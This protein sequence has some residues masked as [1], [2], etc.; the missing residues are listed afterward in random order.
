VAPQ[1][2]DACVDNDAHVGA[3]RAAPT[4]AHLRSYT[5]VR[6]HIR[7]I[8]Q[9]R[10]LNRCACSLDELRLALPVG[11]LCNVK[12]TARACVPAGDSPQAMVHFQRSALSRA[13]CEPLRGP[14]SQSQFQSRLLL[15]P[16]WSGLVH[17]HPAGP[18]TTE[19]APLR[20]GSGSPWTKPGQL[21]MRR[22][23]VRIRQRTQREVWI[24]RDLIQAFAF[25]GCSGERGYRPRRRSMGP[26]GHLTAPGSVTA[27]RRPSYCPTVSAHRT[28]DGA[29]TYTVPRPRAVFRCS[30]L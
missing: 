21:V 14:G 18:L 15:S 2:R 13:P 3:A 5:Q 6:R 20:D 4:W 9:L 28:G 12:P 17:A 7:A 24:G 22:S 16:A 29:V 1:L 30:S 26:V 11:G 8:R 23:S 19:V 27:G 10:G 25:S